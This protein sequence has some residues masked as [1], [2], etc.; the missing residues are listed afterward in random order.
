MHRLT[1]GILVR[2]LFAILLASCGPAA[3]EP[4]T[5]DEPHETSGSAATPTDSA[6]APAVD[7]E[8]W[9][10]VV[11][12]ERFANIGVVPLAQLSRGSSAAI[13][14]W[15]ALAPD[16]TILDDDVIGIT[17]EQRDGAWVETH[18]NWGMRD[19]DARALIAQQLGGSDFT[20]RERNDGA[21]FAELAQRFIDATAAFG[22]AF[23]AA[24]RDRFIE[25]AVGVSLLMTVEAT[26]GDSFTD[27]LSRV[28]DGGRFEI[29]QVD[30]Q[31]ARVTLRFRWNEREGEIPFRAVRVTPDADR[32][33]LELP[34]S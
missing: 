20:I 4:T 31:N 3:T 32:W 5:L 7:P 10:I 8:L 6:P 29:V 9:A 2:T 22:D 27:M 24:D 13:L 21:P 12:H 28:S 34:P 30:E 11:G 15:P 14:A 23:V 33:V 26:F 1:V 16:N 18:G 25:A 17:L 19:D